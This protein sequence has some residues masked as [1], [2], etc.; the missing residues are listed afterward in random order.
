MSKDQLEF[1]SIDSERAHGNLG[2]AW[3]AS[4]IFLRSKTTLN[5]RYHFRCTLCQKEGSARDGKLLAHI[6]ECTAITS[7]QKRAFNDEY[8]RLKAAATKGDQQLDE[9]DE[10]MI[11]K[12][13]KNYV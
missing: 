11:D 10:V 6:D 13:R 7:T 9:I 3:R 4:N 2:P 1:E 5:G 12:I 8:K